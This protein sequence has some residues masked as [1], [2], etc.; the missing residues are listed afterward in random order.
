QSKDMEMISTIDSLDWR[1]LPPPIVARI[2]CRI[3]FRGK[4]GEPDYY[5]SP[6]QA[7][8][9]AIRCYELD[10]SPFSGETWFNKLNHKVNLTLEGK[11]ALSRKNGYRIGVPHFTDEAPRPW[12][13]AAVAKQM[14]ALLGL[15]Q[16]PGITCTLK[17]KS[18]IGIEEVS[19]TAWL[20]EWFMPFSPVWKEKSGHMLRVRAHEKAISS[21]SGVGISELPDDK[22]IEPAQPIVP[23]IETVSS[24]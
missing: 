3:P 17:V 7:M 15:E 24:V 1:K 6:T 10:L 20:G 18:E 13:N 4:S 23:Q 12:K 2:L 16:E 8:I 9:W 21:A 5:L 14:V 22:D 19:Y 11:L